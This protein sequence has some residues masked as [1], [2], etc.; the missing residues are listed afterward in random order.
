[1]TAAAILAII[2]AT[3]E[4][5]DPATAIMID[6]AGESLGPDIAVRL[7]GA[8]QPDAVDPLRIERES[9]A[10]AVVT[11]VW[12]DASRLRARMRLHVAASGHTTTREVVFSEAD[13]RVERGR[14][15]G[16]AAA[17]MW[18]EI[19]APAAAEPAP[20]A[21][22]NEPVAAPAASVRVAPV[23]PAARHFALGLAALGA[24]GDA[25]A[26]GGRVESVFAAGGSWAF[27]AALSARTGSVPA[28]ADGILWKFCVSALSARRLRVAHSLMT[29]SEPRKPRAF[30]RRQS[31]APFRQPDAYCS[32]SHG[33]SRSNELWRVRKTSV[34][35]PRIT[36]R[37]SFLLW[38]V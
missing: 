18:P 36:C 35:A 11:L 10:G 37:T 30:K 17:S 15:L 34:R 32:S 7:L 21:R 31:S 38:P 20:P 16:L 26:V 14:T 13:T 22:G 1:M 23:A 28:L 5:N 24:S 19:R 8:D 12:R 9:G 29:R 27:R 33:K 4:I 6:A 25:R 2:V 3:T